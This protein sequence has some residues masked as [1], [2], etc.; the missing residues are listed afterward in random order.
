MEIA[1]DTHRLGGWVI[2]K[3]GLEAMKRREILPPPRIEP[4]P[5]TRSYID[6]VILTYL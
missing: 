2:F 1:P 6:W 5:F 3:A 4:Q